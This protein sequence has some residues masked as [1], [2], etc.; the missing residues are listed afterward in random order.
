MSS[1]SCCAPQS[2]NARKKARKKLLRSQHVDIDK[3]ATIKRRA[4]RLVQQSETLTAEQ[5]K[6]DLSVSNLLGN[7]SVS[8]CSSTRNSRVNHN[9]PHQKESNS[10]QRE[11][12]STQ[13][14]QRV[15][16]LILLPK[17]AFVPKE[18][19]APTRED[20]IA[21]LETRISIAEDLRSQRKKKKD[22]KGPL[23]MQDL[24]ENPQKMMESLSGASSEELIK[25]QQQ[26]QQQLNSFK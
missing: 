7:L 5:E 23:N 2:K 14:R 10:T 9:E 20:L 25:I 6:I 24:M 21:R 1:P 11:S 13:K 19:I 16:P 26:L 4:P 18:K 8:D 15:A 3:T 12:N 17:E 22:S